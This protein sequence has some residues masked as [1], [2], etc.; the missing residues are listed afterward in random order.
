[1]GGASFECNDDMGILFIDWG[2]IERGV[3]CGF[4]LCEWVGIR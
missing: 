1:M 3:G 4:D 2:I